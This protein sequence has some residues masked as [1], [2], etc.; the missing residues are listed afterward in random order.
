M[1][2]L[3]TGRWSEPKI[4]GDNI[5]GYCYAT[6]EDDT[7]LVVFQTK[8]YNGLDIYGFVVPKQR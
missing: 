1:E 6:A 2:I 7:N 8:F 4:I 5:F 3:K